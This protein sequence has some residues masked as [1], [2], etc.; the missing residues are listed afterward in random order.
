ME[1]YRTVRDVIEAWPSAEHFSSDLGLKYP[2]HGRVM[3][4]RNRIPRAHWDAVVL[5]ASKRGIDGITHRLLENLHNSAP[6]AQAEDA[7]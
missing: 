6:A 2:S 1:T 5:S 4:I 3:K 7:A